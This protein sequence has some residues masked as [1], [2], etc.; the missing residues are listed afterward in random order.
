MEEIRNGAAE[1]GDSRFLV[2]MAALLILCV[3]GFYVS[4]ESSVVFLKTRIDPDFQSA[5]SINEKVNCETVERS[6]WAVVP[7]VA[8]VPGVV[9]ATTAEVAGRMPTAVFAMVGYALIAAL[10]LLAFMLRRQRRELGAVFLLALVCLVFSF[11]LVYVMHFVIKSWCTLCLTSDLVNIGLFV[12]AL[13]ALKQ[14]GRPLWASVRETVLSDLRWIFG[15]PLVLGLHLLLGFGL[16]GAAWGGVQLWVS[17]LLGDAV[18]RDL[19]MEASVRPEPGSPDWALEA[20]PNKECGPDC[21]CHADEDGQ[22]GKEVASV[23]MGVDAGGLHWIGSQKPSVIIEEFTDYECPHCRKAHM[24]LRR[25]LSMHPA[26]LKVVHRHFPLDQACNPMLTTPFHKDA[27][28]LSK[29]AHCAGLQGRFWEMN[30]LLFQKAPELKA[31]SIDVDGIAKLLELD[32]DKFQCCLDATETAAALEA[33][34]RRGIELKIS[35]TPAFVIGGKVFLGRIPDEV[36]KPL[37][38]DADAAGFDKQ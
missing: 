23:M 12:M 13:L 22:G 17:P 6:R 19:S 8:G 1:A 34:I 36:L 16:L 5:C 27:C 2:S 33:D 31:G 32:L 38:I 35:G 29:A 37:R 4:F 25:L 14:D 28:R 10:V 15:R 11:L 21:T 26:D 7:F 3:T 18:A 9:E 24:R 20:V 30:D